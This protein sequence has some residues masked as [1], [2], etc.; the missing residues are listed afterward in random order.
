M[1]IKLLS[2]MPVVLCYGIL[3]AAAKPE[4]KVVSGEVKVESSFCSRFD[5]NPGAAR[6]LIHCMTGSEPEF[7]DVWP[8]GSFCTKE[9][10]KWAALI[11]EKTGL[12]FKRDEVLISLIIS[13]VETHSWHHAPMS[14][15]LIHTNPKEGDV[16]QREDGRWMPFDIRRYT[17]FVA[18]LW[19]YALFLKAKAGDTVE[20]PFWG[21]AYV[22]KLK[23]AE[24]AH[25]TFQKNAA[26]AVAA[27]L[28]E[29][30]TD[31]EGE[32]LKSLSS[33]IEFLNACLQ[34]VK[35]S[36]NVQ[37]EQNVKKCLDTIYCE[38]DQIWNQRA[39]RLLKEQYGDD[40]TW[41]EEI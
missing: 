16:Q 37:I 30:K 26:R 35:D 22:A 14:K 17:V 33:R 15:Q 38:Y 29:G 13:D 19:P 4:P 6:D 9:P 39:S 1:K 7:D 24:N 41:S 11:A 23:I 10:E 34:S 21:G 31:E 3:Q 20:I 40:F 36:N 8:T 25:G 28:M 18:R 5:T 27:F 32:R 12:P 2:I